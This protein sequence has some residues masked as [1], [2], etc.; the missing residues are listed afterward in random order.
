ML[1]G[2]ILHTVFRLYYLKIFAIVTHSVGSV[3]SSDSELTELF[4]F[5]PALEGLNS[6][7]RYTVH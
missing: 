1:L 3:E 4:Q 6:M 2:S 5:F 7:N